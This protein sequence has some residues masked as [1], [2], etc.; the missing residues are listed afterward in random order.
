LELSGLERGFV[1]YGR[2]GGNLRVRASRSIEP[3]E[4]QAPRFAGSATAVEQVLREARTVVCCDTLDT[5]WLGAR[6]SVR[7]GGIRALVC[8]P[9]QGAGRPLGAIYADSR[10]PGPALT[11]LDLELVE[12]IAQHAAAALA[13]AELQSAGP[14]SIGP[15][16][17]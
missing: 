12:N 1:L 14:D 15:Q 17:T 8:L 2:H 13:A 6:P 5:P 7:L 9:L 10:R 11:E 4:I 16:H 3:D